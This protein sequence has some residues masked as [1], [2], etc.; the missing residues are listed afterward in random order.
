MIDTYDPDLPLAVELVEAPSAPAGMRTAEQ[1]RECEPDPKDVFDGVTYYDPGAA[2][3]GMRA[4]ARPSINGFTCGPANEI[5]VKNYYIPGTEVS[6]PGGFRAEVAPLL[7]GFW[8]DFNIQVEPLSKGW[9]WGY[10]ARDVRG[11]QSPSF[12]W[13]G[14]AGD[15]NAPKHP[16]GKRGTFNG[17]Q[18]SKMREL[19]KRYG[20]RLGA[21]YRSR[22]DEMHVE[23]ILRR[24]DALELV[25]KMQ[26]NVP[27]WPGHDVTVGDTGWAVKAIQQ[28]VGASI[29]GKYG[30]ATRSRVAGWQ[31][32]NHLGQTGI[33]DRSTWRLMFGN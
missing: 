11:S 32:N 1:Y 16:M 27:T 31:K 18:L 20:L 17:T 29:D 6:F 7:L 12:H 15:G 5:G 10:A 22:A 14:I 3:P 25:K 9:C 21:D 28:K 23:I 13:A 33:V 8:R 2:Q 26:A 24:P 4:S 30:P 19:A